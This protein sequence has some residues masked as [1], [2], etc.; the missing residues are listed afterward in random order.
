M[1]TVWWDLTTTPPQ[2]TTGA[3]PKT[4]LKTKDP[5]VKRYIQPF[6][7]EYKSLFLQGEAGERP[8]PKLSYCGGPARLYPLPNK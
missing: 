7:G 6:K 2:K 4:I 5:S 3:K 1:C 8:S